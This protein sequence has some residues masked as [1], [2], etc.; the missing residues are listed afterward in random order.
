[1]IAGVYV[2]GCLH[3]DISI[4]STLLPVASRPSD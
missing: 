3:H 4:D 1:M 2:G